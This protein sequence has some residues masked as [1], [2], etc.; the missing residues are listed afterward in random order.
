MR[1]LLVLTLFIFSSIATSDAAITVMSYNVENLFDSL[2]DPGKDDKAYLPYSLK[3]N[4]DHIEACN[5]VRVKN[6]KMNVY[7]LTGLKVPKIKN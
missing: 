5:K 3:Q 2:D 6:G 4:K 7:I 1:N